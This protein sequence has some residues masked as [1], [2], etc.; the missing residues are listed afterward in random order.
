MGGDWFHL[1]S[2]VAPLSGAGM[3]QPLLG[4]TI[5]ARY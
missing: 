3:L 4:I 1:I 2:G 5:L